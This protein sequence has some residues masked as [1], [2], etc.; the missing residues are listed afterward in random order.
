MNTP[1]H[2]A[3]LYDIAEAQAGYFTAAQ[4]GAAG[5]DRRRLAYYAVP[6]GCNAFIVASTG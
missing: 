4:A 3:R 2:L 1:N 5:V 6:A